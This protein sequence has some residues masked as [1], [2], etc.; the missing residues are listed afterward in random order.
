MA[1]MRLEKQATFFSPSTVLRAATGARKIFLGNQTAPVARFSFGWTRTIFYC[2]S[3]GRQRAVEIS[4]ALYERRSHKR[5][6]ANAAAT[7][8]HEARTGSVAARFILIRTKEP[9][10]VADES[11]IFVETD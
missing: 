10:S 9:G 2:R 3:A 8:Q 6:P 7:G 1:R 4:C 5:N 11:A